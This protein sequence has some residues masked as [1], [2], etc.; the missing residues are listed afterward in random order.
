MTPLPADVIAT[1][2]ATAPAV[3]AHGTAIVARMY[4]LMFAANPEVREMFNPAHMTLKGQI[5]A[6]AEAVAAYAANI[7][8]LE[9]LAPAVERISQK[10]ASLG[11][12]PEHY[13]VVGRHLLQAI[14]DVLGVAATADVIAAWTKAYGFLANLFIGREQAVVAAQA[15]A[16]GG[17]AGLRDF[18]VVRKVAE[19]ATIT[20]FYLAPADGKP[21][22]AFHPGQYIAV[23]TDELAPAGAWR[24]YSLSDRPGAGHFRVSVKREP[25]A[26]DSHPAGV[27]S[28][29]LHDR[30]REGDAVRVSAPAGD[31][32]L[33]EPIERPVVLLSGGV[34]LTVMMSMLAHLSKRGSAQPVHF[35]HAATHSVVHAF[36]DE[37]KTLCARHANFTSHVRYWR[38]TA[39]CVPGRDYDST[40][41][42]DVALVQQVAGTLDCDFYLCGPKP[43][44]RGLHWG[45]TSAGVPVDRVHFEFF[46]PAS[47]ITA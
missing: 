13:P 31:F 24:N 28:N 35:I 39:D 14:R 46:G 15:A 23:R 22:P 4:D 6:L 26:G 38:P 29:H 1:V 34:G 41:E 32:F 43:F 36:R 5:G 10:H 2:K 21:L 25:T 20:S 42:V 17:W 11:V 40:G 9:V 12:R 16:P 45:L 7:D 8:R 27:V 47:D 18:R 44:M 3:A 37:V 30:V 19:S 33:I